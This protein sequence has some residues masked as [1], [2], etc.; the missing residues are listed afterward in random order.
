MPALRLQITTQNTS[1]GRGQKGCVPQR[2]GLCEVGGGVITS[3]QLQ[4]C[5]EAPSRR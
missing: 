4:L 2:A 1:H 5:N 3:K